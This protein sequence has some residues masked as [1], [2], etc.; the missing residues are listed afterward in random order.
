MQIV[1]KNIKFI[2]IVLFCAVNLF[3]FSSKA[4][5]QEIDVF[6]GK[7]NISINEN[8]TVTIL[9]P[10]DNKREYKAFHQYFFPDIADFEKGRTLFLEE[11]DD[12]VYKIIQYF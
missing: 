2:R 8:F 1:R 5:T 12:K 4:Y 7:T 3:I 9:F 10:K 11:E 6:A